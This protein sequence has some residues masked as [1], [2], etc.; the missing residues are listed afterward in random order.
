MGHRSADRD[1]E[2][3]WRPTSLELANLIWTRSAHHHAGPRHDKA[4]QRG[5][6]QD[7]TRSHAHRVRKSAHRRGIQTGMPITPRC[8]LI[9]MGWM[10]P[11][12]GIAMCQ[13]GDA[14]VTIGRGG[15][16]V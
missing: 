1:R 8:G 6:K 5:L 13:D 4:A 11:P 14:E 15:I 9:L 3:Q 2:N 16:H 12:D 7:R 10:P